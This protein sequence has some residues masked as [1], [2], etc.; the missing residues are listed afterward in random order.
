M[1]DYHPDSEA[2]SRDGVFVSFSGLSRLIHV[3]FE[4]SVQHP[5]SN[6]GVGCFSKLETEGEPQRHILTAGFCIFGRN[7][8]RRDYDMVMTM[9]QGL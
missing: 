6:D 2:P 5:V 4:G 8:I 3:M 1:T 7:T 9:I